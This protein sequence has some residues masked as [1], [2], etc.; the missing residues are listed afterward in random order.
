MVI[1]RRFNPLKGV[2][3]DALSRSYSHGFLISGGAALGAALLTAIA[4]RARSD[5]P[6][7][8]LGTLDE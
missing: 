5:E 8:D 7:P 1:Q 4:I 6:M 3:F 2:A